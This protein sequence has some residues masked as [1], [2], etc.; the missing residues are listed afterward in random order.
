MRKKK[1]GRYLASSEK[2]ND[3]RSVSFRHKRVGKE[4]ETHKHTHPGFTPE[5]PHAEIYTRCR[6]EDPSN[7]NGSPDEKN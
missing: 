7:G 3:F 5:R 1:E 2:Q 4:R 6:L